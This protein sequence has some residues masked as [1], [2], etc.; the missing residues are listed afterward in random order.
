MSHSSIFALLTPSGVL[1]EGKVGA[2]GGQRIR[3]HHRE[4]RF[5]HCQSRRGRPFYFPMP[6]DT[7]GERFPLRRNPKVGSTTLY[8]S[9]TA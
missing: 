6:S 7:G 8:K 2:K 4:S 5:N 9:N 3:V 1:C